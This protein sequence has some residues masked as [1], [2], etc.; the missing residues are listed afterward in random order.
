MTKKFG[1]FFPSVDSLQ[2]LEGLLTYLG[3]KVSIGNTC[4]YCEKS[5]YSLGAVRDHMVCRLRALLL[6]TSF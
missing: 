5:F 3:Q 6:L 4:L 2:D 1:F